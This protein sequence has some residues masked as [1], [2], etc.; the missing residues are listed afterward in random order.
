MA[1]RVGFEPTR[2]LRPLRAFQARLFDHSSTSPFVV[3]YHRAVA[4]GHPCRLQESLDGEN[5]GL[6]RV[7]LLHQHPVHLLV[8]VR[9]GIGHHKQFEANVRP[10]PYRGQD[11]PAGCHSH[12]DQRVTPH[13]PQGRFEA[14]SGEGSLP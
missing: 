10:L 3:F 2:G 14:G 9:A 1:E 12:E 6:T 11:A 5:G 7:Q 8:R 13:D 4:S